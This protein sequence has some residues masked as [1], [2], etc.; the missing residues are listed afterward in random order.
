VTRDARQ[1]LVRWIAW[2]GLLA[3]LTVGFVAI[4]A[5]VERV[6]VALAYLLVVLGGSAT[7]G[8][9]LGRTLAI[10]A[11]LAFHYF[12]VE[13]LRPSRRVSAPTRSPG[14]QASAPRR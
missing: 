1:A 6:H 7:G 9:R 5:H 2:L 12:F 8:R 11:Y 4:R 10:L 14:W 3:A 13:H